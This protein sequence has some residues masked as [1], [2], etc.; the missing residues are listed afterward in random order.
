M[1]DWFSDRWRDAFYW[2]WCRWTNHRG[3][4]WRIDIAWK[5]GVGHLRWRVCRRCTR[6]HR[7]DIGA[8]EDVLEADADP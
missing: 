7:D 4:S 5:V 6:I 2:G 3:A 1:T 8:V